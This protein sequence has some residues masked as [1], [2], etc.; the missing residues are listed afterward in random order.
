MRQLHSIGD[1][2]V[3]VNE[4]L[5]G[6]MSAGRFVTAALCMVDPATE[7]VE[8]FSA[9]HG[10]ILLYTAHSGEV[11]VVDTDEL[12][13]GIAEMQGGSELLPR[14][15]AE[16]DIV[17]LT[18]DGFF[19]WFNASREQYGIAAL[20]AFIQWNHD[21]APEDFI[22]ALHQDVL[23]HAAGVTQ[24]DDLTVVIVKR[25]NAV[26]IAEPEVPAILRT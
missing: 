9:G 22:R 19:E 7:S 11:T 3:Q 8:I 1:A 15:F 14:P 5:M 17:V 24:A 23:R 13:L 10:P 25:T 12:P 4:L 16:G 2:V 18:T 6:D 20:K 26:A 21:M